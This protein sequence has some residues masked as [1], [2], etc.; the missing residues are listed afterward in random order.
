MNLSVMSDLDGNIAIGT[1]YDHSMEVRSG[2][3]KFRLIVLGIVIII[4]TLLMSSCVKQTDFTVADKNYVFL[5]EDIKGLD[6]KGY[7]IKRYNTGREYFFSK[8]VNRLHGL[9]GTYGMMVF[10]NQNHEIHL[11][12]LFSIQ[13]SKAGAVKLFESNLNTLSMI[14]K[15]HVK[16]IDP[17]YYHADQ[18][19]FFALEEQ[20]I[21]ALQKGNLFYMVDID[22]LLLREGQF[23]RNLS[24]KVDYLIKNGVDHFKVASF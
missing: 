24:A 20:A 14:W 1:E 15:K 3:R 2:L 22:G 21:V 6:L 9:Y 18:A 16:I 7:Q 11:K 19:F 13:N 5:M 12:I 23:R 4:I 8:E 10:N 17:N